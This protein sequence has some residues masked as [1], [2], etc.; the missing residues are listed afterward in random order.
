MDKPRGLLSKT[1]VFSIIICFMLLSPSA[2]AITKDRFNHP[3]DAP[4]LDGPRRVRPGTYD[5]TFRAVDPDGDDLF[6]EIM[7]GDDT[8]EEWIGPYLS[9]EEIIVNHT[10][11]KY[12]QV[13]IRAR[14]KD[15][16]G[17][18]GDWGEMAIEISETTQQLSSEPSN[19]DTIND[20]PIS[21]TI[22]DNGSLSGYV[23]DIFGNP[24]ERAL[25]RVYFH[26]TYE[27]DYSDSTGYY[28]VTN[29]PICYCLKNAT[30]SKEWYK[31]E[32]VLLGI[33]ENTTHDFVLTFFTNPPDAPEID[34]EKGVVPGVEFDYYFSAIDSDGDDVRYHI[35]WGDGYTNTT[36][37]Y[38]S[39]EE[40]TIGHTYEKEGN[41]GIEAKAIDI[42]GAESDW[43]YYI[44]EWRNRALNF[45]LFEWLFERFPILE[46]LLNLL[47]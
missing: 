22:M 12:A 29:I 8:S 24:I 9:G 43:G 21:R 13:A 45:N 7:W 20:V 32:W 47:R 11:H 6:Y 17:D 28:H 14:A 42:Y 40:V 25:V 44:P 35:N 38:S 18:I 27:E 2:F 16:H 41:Y 26:E 34:G 15:I 37:F 19:Q 33:V 23:N 36:D 1:L 3:P 39:G 10:Y 46:K 4:W 31:T 5:W 30:C